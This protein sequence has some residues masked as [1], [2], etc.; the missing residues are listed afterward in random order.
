MRGL[1][2]GRVIVDTMK[3][4]VRRWGN[5]L[6]LRIPK[7]F[8]EEAGLREDGEVEVTVE[9]GALRVEAVKEQTWS[10][11]GLLAGVSRRNLHRTVGT[12][13]PVGRE[14]W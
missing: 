3:A 4:T 5:S 12:G 2:V 6:A 1:D 11:D 8:A 14:E 10:L 13:S 9:A 7:P